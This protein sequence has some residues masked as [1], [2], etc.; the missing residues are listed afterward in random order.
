MLTTDATVGAGML[1]GLLGRALARSFERV[2][3][4]QAPGMAD[5]AVLLANA[6]AAARPCGPAPTGPPPSS[7][8]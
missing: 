7:R 3:V 8:P 1:D 6:T 5:A 4:D 2:M